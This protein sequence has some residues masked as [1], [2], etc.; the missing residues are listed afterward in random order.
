[1]LDGIGRMPVLIIRTSSFSGIM[2]IMEIDVTMKQVQA[3]QDGE[4]IQ[5][6]MPELTSTEREF[7]VTGMSE[8]E[9]EVYY[10]KFEE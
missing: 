8:R 7:L 9:Q 5:N 1:M 2:N 6:V 4:L 10:A 3:W